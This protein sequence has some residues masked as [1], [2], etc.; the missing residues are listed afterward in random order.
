MIAPATISNCGPA[1]AAMPG[2]ALA[3]KPRME[4]SNATRKGVATPAPWPIARIDNCNKPAMP[5]VEA[6]ASAARLAS[7]RQTNSAAMTEISAM[8][9][10]S[11]EN[12]VSANCPRALDS[13]SSTVAGPAKA[14]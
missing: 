10:N 11:G 9:N 7:C 12:A 3:I 4:A 5:T 13:A 6:I 8:L 2:I 1:L 14:R